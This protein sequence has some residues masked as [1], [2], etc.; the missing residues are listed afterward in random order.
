MMTKYVGAIDQGTTSS[1]FMIFDRKGEVKGVSQEEFEQI[2]PKPGWVEHD[3]MAIM[4]TVENTIK[5]ALK[6]AD[7]TPK[8]LAAIGVTNQR[9]TT[10]IWDKYTGT[11]YYNAIV[12]QDTRTDYICRELEK[13]GGQGRWIEKTGLPITTYFSCTKIRWILDNVP[14]LQE[15][16]EKGEVLFGNIDT[17]VIW[18][19]TGGPNGGLH[20]TDVSNG[21]RTQL[22]NIHTCEWDD[23]ILQVLNIPKVML[24]KIMPSSKNYGL[25]K[26]LLEGVPI[27]GD[28]GDQQAAVFGQTCFNKGDG[29]CTY[30]TALCLLYNTGTEPVYS[31]AGL[32]TTVGYKIGDDGPVHYILE[33]TNATGG[34]VVQWLRDNLKI[35]TKSSDIEA[36]AKT[37][38][39]NGGAYFV[40]AF[41]GLFAPYWKTDA[42]GLIIGLTR[43]VNNAHIARASLESLCYQTKEM[44]D[45][46]SQDW[47]VTFNTLK[48]DG[49]AVHNE[50][51]MQF[52]ADMLNLQVIRP[53]CTETTALG[54]AYAAG[55][56]VGYWESMQDLCDNWAVEKTWQPQM[57][58]ET[59]ANHYKGW[60]KAVER[61]MAWID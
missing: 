51:L 43:Y 57:D 17:W 34:V 40:P 27:A 2:F 7:I 11:P 3:P 26:G 52:L 8:D 25:C 36:L 35:I 45:A 19:I 47:G 61:T 55:L 15:K 31:S 48:V 14:G 49:G 44:L 18:N 10:V 1:R 16:A 4:R 39:D 5:G 29:K 22:M 60:I 42:R 37:V 32:L 50:I 58:A 54:A 33:G 56:A 23:E 30:G 41:S 24:P 28:L 13:D 53:V 20:I 38:D 6:D 12:W 21:S 59:R 46:M 9:E